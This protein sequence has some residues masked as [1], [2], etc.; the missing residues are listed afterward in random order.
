MLVSAADI[1]D[2]SVTYFCCSIALFLEMKKR[3][4]GLILNNK[5]II[6]GIMYIIIFTFTSQSRTKKMTS[7]G[8]T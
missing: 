4:V 5:R 8:S 3:L 2:I 7:S 1:N 6:F